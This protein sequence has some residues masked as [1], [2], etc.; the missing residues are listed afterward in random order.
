MQNK[1]QQAI[2]M[3]QREIITLAETKLGRQ[4]TDGERGGIGRISSLM[5]LESICRSFTAPGYTAAQVLADLEHF[6]SQ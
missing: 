3:S 6:A 1:M 2:E 5:M 4:L